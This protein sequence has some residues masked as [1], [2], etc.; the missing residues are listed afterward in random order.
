MNEGC[1]I[2]SDPPRNEE[3]DYIALDSTIS[4][5]QTEELN[6]V[7]RDVDSLGNAALVRT[8][9][10]QVHATPSS[11]DLELIEDANS[12]LAK[13]INGDSALSDAQLQPTVIGAVGG[14]LEVISS[15]AEFLE[16]TSRK[17]LA[18]TVNSLVAVSSP[19]KSSLNSG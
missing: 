11:E 16:T 7:L 9:S 19:M 2:E 4:N 8:N 14:A 18:N 13:L 15:N 10:S 1:A 17:T 6:S 5:E 3:T 12:N